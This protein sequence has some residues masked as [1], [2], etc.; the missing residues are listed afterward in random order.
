M[1]RAEIG[2]WSCS[3]WSVDVRVNPLD[4]PCGARF[5]ARKLELAD[6][7]G[8]LGCRGGRG[9]ARKH[10]RWRISSWR[11]D[12]G[13]VRPKKGPVQETGSLDLSPP[14]S[15]DRAIAAVTAMSA[16]HALTTAVPGRWRTGGLKCLER[17]RVNAGAKERIACGQSLSA[18][19]YGNRWTRGQ[20]YAGLGSWAP[21]LSARSKLELAQMICVLCGGDHDPGVSNCDWNGIDAVVAKIRP[22]RPGRIKRIN[23][24]LYTQ[25]SECGY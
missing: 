18:S 23:T 11:I 13:L 12:G 4:P 25:L 16:A 2:H 20:S 21:L 9:K 14:L 1:G 6:V 15:A 19:S 10:W 24:A 3:A 8:R 17:L 5:G 22:R 7:E